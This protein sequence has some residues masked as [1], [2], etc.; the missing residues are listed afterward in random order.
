ML[1]DQRNS[2]TCDSEMQ[3]NTDMSEVGGRKE[4]F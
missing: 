2:N 4:S 3:E 1:C